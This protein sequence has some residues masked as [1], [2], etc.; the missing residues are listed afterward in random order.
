MDYI[1]DSKTH[2]AMVGDLDLLPPKPRFICDICGKAYKHL[3]NTKDGKKVCGKCNRYRVTNKFYIP[4]ELRKENN[5]ISKFNI[6]DTEKNVL[7][8]CNKKSIK[9]VNNT[10]R[11]L[12]G[13]KKKVRY[14]E[15]LKEQENKSQENL[16]KNLVEG[17]YGKK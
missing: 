8:L 16:N 2:E 5:H 14:K 17:L 6:T 1:Q 15:K 4:K 9:R 3:E 12:Q 11:V 13:I 7:I 10:Q